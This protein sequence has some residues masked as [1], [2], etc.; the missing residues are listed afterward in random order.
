M[1]KIWQ[2]KDV[3]EVIP[4]SAGDDDMDVYIQTYEGGEDDKGRD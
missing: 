1:G 3:G 4:V 2:L